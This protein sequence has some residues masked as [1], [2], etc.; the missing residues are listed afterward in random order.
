MDY[1]ELCGL[2]FDS[3]SVVKVNDK[4]EF[5]YDQYNLQFAT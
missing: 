2:H 1:G 3:A 5:I 4:K